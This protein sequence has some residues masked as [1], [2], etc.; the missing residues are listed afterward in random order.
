MEPTNCTN[1]IHIIECKFVVHCTDF[2]TSNTSAD[3]PITGMY[4]NARDYAIDA[5]LSQP[6]PIRYY[7]D[8]RGGKEEHY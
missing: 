6:E 3:K 7:R 2:E 8:I 4:D 1:C 5:A